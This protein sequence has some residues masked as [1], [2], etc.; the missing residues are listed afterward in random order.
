MRSKILVFGNPL[1]KADSLPLR[2]IE[3]LRERFPGVEFEEFD[4]NDNL[5]KEGRRLTIID[6]VEGIDRVTLI[7]DIDSIR[8]QTVYSMHDFDLG[9]SLKLLKKMG[10]VDSVKIFGVPMKMDVDEALEQLTEL[11]R[12]NLS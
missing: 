2:I 4:P 3:G 8:S 12:A 5:E 6:S 7:T 11:I 9:H 1:L 10:Y